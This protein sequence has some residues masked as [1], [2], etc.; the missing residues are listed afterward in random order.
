MKRQCFDLQAKTKQKDC[1]YIHLFSK[2]F[3]KTTLDTELQ[4]IYYARVQPV[5]TTHYCKNK[6]L[7]E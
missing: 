5:S 4:T 1:I 6:H 7:F 2:Q 3:N